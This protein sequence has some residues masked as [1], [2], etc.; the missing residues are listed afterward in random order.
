VRAPVEATE[1]DVSLGGRNFVFDL[2]AT[3]YKTQSRGS[4]LDTISRTAFSSRTQSDGR[5]AKLYSSSNSSTQARAAD[6]TVARAKQ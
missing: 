4:R 5:P 3:P 1:L 6:L 2:S